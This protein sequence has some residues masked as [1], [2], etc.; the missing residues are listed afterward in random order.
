[1]PR[2]S[3]IIPTYNRAHLIRETLDSVFA[4]TFH[5]FETIIVDDGSEDDTA[6]V[7][8]D[9]QARIT[10]RQIPHAGASAARNAGMEIARGEF[11]AFLDSDDLWDARFLEK[12][13]AVLD[14][15]SSAGFAYC[16]YATFDQR[17]IIQV[18]Y[19]PSQHKIRGYLFPQLLECDFIST[20]A[21]LI[22]RACLARVGEFDLR[23]KVAHDWDMWLRLARQFDA[24]YVDEP[25]ARIRIDSR[26]LSQ[27]TAAI[28]A[29]NLQVLS[30]VRRELMGGDRRLRPIIRQN[31]AA[32]HYALSKYFRI[33]RR[34]LPT[35][36]HY[37]LMIAAKFL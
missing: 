24:E 30:K 8:A 7:L 9:L 6:H 18:A 14:A 20:G 19:L 15:A 17:G 5:D 2:V 12:M 25:L 1:M 26:G 16:D 36:K 13:T 32:N 35:L 4:Q 11:I 33:T 22:R 23:L 29:D 37:G 28:H 31:I 21:L 34:L 10:Y 3:I 27:D